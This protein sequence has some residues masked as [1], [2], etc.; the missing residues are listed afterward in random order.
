MT[1]VRSRLTVDNPQLWSPE[2]PV[3]YDLSIEV[4]SENGALLDQITSY[5]GLREVRCEG[6]AILLNGEPQYLKG[7]LDQG[8]FPAVGIRLRMMRHC[9]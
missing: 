2:N 7:V 1:R 5:A 6:G 8:Y 4:A 9:A 3:L